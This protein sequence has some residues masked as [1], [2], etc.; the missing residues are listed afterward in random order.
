MTNFLIL[1]Q[2]NDGWQNLAVD[3]YLLR[4]IKAG[5]MIL[6]I[7]VNN[8]CVVIG[9]HQNPWRECNLAAMDTDGVKLVRRISGGGAVFHDL[10]NLNFSF[11]TDKKRYNV[12]RQMGVILNTIRDLGISGEFSGR[13]DILVQGKKFS[14]NAFCD[15]RQGCQ[16]HGT[17]LVDTD[18]SN[19]SKYLQV[20]EKKIRDKG[21]SSVKARVC[22]LSDFAQGL[23]VDMVKDALCR[24][25]A[26][27]YGGYKPLDLTSTA[28]QEIQDLYNKQSSWQWRLGHTPQFDIVL[29]ERFSW[30]EIQLHLMVKEGIITEAKVYSDALDINLPPTIGQLVQGVV[31]SPAELKAR[32]LSVAGERE[33]LLAVA[34]WLGQL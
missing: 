11:I 20:S 17:L 28:K 34:Q 31:F 29:E 4:N 16:H 7:Y 24:A 12:P 5:D 14:G 8:N 32:I 3:E 33:E 10:G 1:H 9:R 13:N 19:L 6:H 30:G 26:A 18:I 21:V 27:E 25:F 23:T 2:G 22:N 15:I